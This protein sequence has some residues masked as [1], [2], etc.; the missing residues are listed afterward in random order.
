VRNADCVNVSF[1]TEHWTDDLR[2]GYAV[3]YANGL[4][5]P[6]F[7]GKD[8]SRETSGPAFWGKV[9]LA[10]AHKGWRKFAGRTA[11]PL[12]VDFRVDPLAAQGFRD[13]TPYQVLK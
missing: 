11:M 5:R 2:A 13:V 10:A 4:L 7:G 3:D 8:L 6:L 9:A 12:T 1:T